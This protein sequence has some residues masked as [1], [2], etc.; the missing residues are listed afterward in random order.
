MIPS[1]VDLPGIFMEPP[2]PGT[3]Q[4]SA[5][6][7]HPQDFTSW[8]LFQGYLPEPY[9]SLP[10]KSYSRVPVS[11]CLDSSKVSTWTRLGVSLSLSGPRPAGL[12][13]IYVCI[14]IVIYTYIYIYI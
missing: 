14:Y 7:L 12:V 8:V 6:E 13:L 11:C 9:R 3:F 2:A 10:H 4:E 1:P 5:N